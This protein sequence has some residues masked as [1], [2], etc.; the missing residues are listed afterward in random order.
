MSVGKKGRE[1]NKERKHDG[2]IRV[3]TGIPKKKKVP[4]STVINSV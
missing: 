1:N 4:K 2:Q 3:G